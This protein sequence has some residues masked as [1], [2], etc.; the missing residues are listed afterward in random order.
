EYLQSIIEEQEATNEEFRI[1]NEEILSSN[2]EFQST[3]EELETAKEEIQATNEELNTINEELQSRNQEV[4]QVNNDLS[5]LLSSVN[6]P[7]VMLSKELDIRLATQSAESV[8]NIIPADVGRSLG[9]IQTNINVPHLEQLIFDVID[10]ASTTELEVKDC[11]GHWYDLR[12]KPYNTAE[13]EIDGA[14]MMLVDIE[15]LKHSELQ[16]REARDYAEAI[17]Q[18]V[19][20]PLIVLNSQ[21]Q[22]KRANRSFYET[23]QVTPEETQ[24]RFIFEL[25][26]H[27]WDIP[28]LRSLLKEIL[29]E[30]T[31][32]TDFEVT[33][34]F[35]NIGNKTMLLNAR[36]IPRFGQPVMMMLLAIEDITSRRQAEEERI[37]LLTLAQEA[38]ESAE[39]ANRAK[40]VFLSIVS[41]ELRT[42]LSTILTWSQMLQSQALNETKTQKGLKAI[43]RCAKSQAMLIE[44]LLDISRITTGKLSLCVCP[45]DLAS[46]I[47]ASINIVQL[48]ADAKT[49]RLESVVNPT[50][51][52]VM[53]DADR[54]QQ[55]MWNLLS[56]AIKFTRKGGRIEVRLEC[57]DST[58]QIEVSDSGMGI[59]PE[60]LPYVFDR[61][62]QDDSA[63][64]RLNGGLGLGLAIVRHLV[65]LHGGTV[66]ASSPG[67][68]QGATF[69]VSLPL[70]S[71]PKEETSVSNDS[72]PLN[73]TDD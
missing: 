52:M 23:F 71:V 43:E 7:I 22:V 42:P 67:E 65:E 15:A 53:G 70:L 46:V 62:R 27:Q 34:Q 49:I 3:N 19:R 17:I 16:I 2:E 12:I 63:G 13:N 9:D 10:T 26:N 37:Q 72:A 39:A 45:V 30:N 32:L 28:R 54:L 14:V 64:T 56:N 35:L 33:H 1:V 31:Q 73:S 40:D 38:C 8:L 57:I 58:A 20:Q 24:D 59:A 66:Q 51:V 47:E 69:T 11:S 55:V 4:S 25:G 6:I 60:F 61:F 18:T 50:I 68:G 21:L 48:S 44:D 41:H 5:N 29:S 36:R